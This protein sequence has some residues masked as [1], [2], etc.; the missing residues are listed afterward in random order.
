MTIEIEVL[1]APGTY[2]A[3]RDPW[4]ELVH[5][6]PQNL[7]GFDA[8]STY[9]WFEATLAAFPEAADSRVIVAREGNEI[10]G[11]LPVL[12]DK[13]KR[14]GP[15]LRTPTE[16][17]GGRTGPL[18]RGSAP[19]LLP[20]LLT[21]LDQACPGWTTL[22]LTLVAGSESART[23]IETCRQRGYG[24]VCG[25]PRESPFFPILATPDEF[26]R[27]IAKDVRRHLKAGENGFKKLGALQYRAYTHEH[28]APALLDAVL[29]IERKTWKHEAGTAITRNPSQERFYRELFPRAMR[30]GLL[31]AEVL[32]LEQQPIAYNFGLHRGGV[33]SCLK[34]SHVQSLDKLTPS[35]LVNLALINNLRNR[36][37]VT[38]DFMG[39]TERHKLRWSNA[40]GVYARG[41]ALR[42]TFFVMPSYAL[43]AAPRI[44]RSRAYSITCRI[45]SCV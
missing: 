4:N 3:L 34:H 11:L 23:L 13:S 29:A 35:H 14:F 10:V 6:D 39:R 5:E 28:E 17:Y 16:L 8:T 19:E 43:A 18:L 20:A 33:Y 31:H 26:L 40:N 27:G 22:Q 30:S 45:S 36:N 7:L 42:T 24:A 44:P 41:S 9:E 1:A 38:Y 21:G 37:T 25:D 32:L 12:I 2:E 15:R